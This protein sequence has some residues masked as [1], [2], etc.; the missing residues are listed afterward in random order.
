MISRQIPHQPENDNYRRLANYIADAS[1]RGQKTLMSWCAGCWSDDEY[2]LAIHEVEA[3]QAL[4]TRSKKE[5][6]YHL[7]ISFRPEDEAKLAPEIFREI[8]LKF[9]KELGFEEHQ[10]HCAVHKNTANVHIHVVYN[11]IHPVRRTRHAPFRDFVTRDRL[12]R[13]LENRYGLTR[14]NGR[15]PAQNS[16]KN[17]KA[18][19]YENQTGQESLF[20]YAQRHKPFIMNELATA[21]TWADCHL[22]FHKC[23]L[24]IQP[25]GNGLVIRDLEG[26]HSIKASDLDRGLSKGKLEKRFGKFKAKALDAEPVPPP[27]STYTAQPVQQGTERDKL[28]ALFNQEIAKRR[29][30]MKEVAEREKR[31]YRLLNEQWNKKWAD[32]KKMPM[33]RK[34]RQA[35]REKFE[36]Q[37]KAE[38]ASFRAE[39]KKLKDTV[40]ARYP[41]TCWS[42]FLQHQARQG[43]ETALLV[44]RSRKAKTTTQAQPQYISLNANND[45]TLAAVTQMREI[46]TANTLKPPELKYDIDGKGT[47]IFSLPNGAIIRD[48]GQGINFS[49]HSEIAKELATKLAQARWGQSVTVQGNIVSK[50]QTPMLNQYQE[51]VRPTK[52]NCMER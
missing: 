46:L 3:V 6:S 10:R 11:Q 37:K 26:Q 24:T 36:S 48:N 9:A 45:N 21:Q 29:A 51:A 19:S 34:D 7:V 30:E 31:L 33:M 18:E 14:D 23:G 22:V 16:A 40:R 47:I 8:E 4:N 32:I 39:I 35:V 38:L 13:Q 52:S 28:Y 49:A 12:C 20:S 5:K 1:H 17:N 15:D 25:H 44:L 50:K 43:N 41:F 2:Q 27:E 42:Q